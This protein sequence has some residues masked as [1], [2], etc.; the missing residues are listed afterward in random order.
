MDTSVGLHEQRVNIDYTICFVKHENE[1]LVVE[2]VKPP[3]K[4]RL[5][6][7]GGKIEPFD[8]TVRKSITREVSEETEGMIDLQKTKLDYC[9]VVS[10]KY[11]AGGEIVL[12]G[13][14]AYIA[15]IS[16]K[17]FATKITRE[18]I[19]TWKPISF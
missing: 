19:L 9:G 2:R 14:H 11:K 12:G 7:L 6:G 16:Q 13:M 10:W 15:E 8:N 1:M 4:G 5:N 17:P 18:G 3:Q